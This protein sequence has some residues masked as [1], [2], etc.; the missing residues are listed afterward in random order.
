M[1][2]PPITAIL[3]AG[4]RPGVDPFAAQFGQTYKALIPVAGVPMLA[5]VA[6][7]L[8]AHPRVGRVLI[9]TQAPDA[10]T[11][12]AATAWLRDEP[13]VTFVAG[14]SS[15]S[16]AIV[17]CLE[18]VPGVLPALVTTAD[19][20]LLTPA[21][22]DAMVT[23][24]DQGTADLL[25]GLVEDRVLLA[26][27]PDSRRTWLRFRAGAYTGCNLFL[28]GTER[29]RSALALWRTVEQDRKKGWRLIAAF[30]PLLALGVALRLWDV[31]Q[32]F[33]RAG[34]RLGLRAAPVLLAQAEAGID[35]DKVED[36]ALA[37]AILAQRESAA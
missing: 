21:M 7:T 8:L 33:A 15:I 6:R 14:G 24:H 27:Y 1:T 30:G 12:P 17:D 19:H 36:H 4:A 11:A 18:S 25:V 34:T 28:L 35:V 5:R 20:A 9:L 22:V 26:G 2:S 31:R 32:A 3:L 23:A 29:V 13:R 10:L 37:E 16:G